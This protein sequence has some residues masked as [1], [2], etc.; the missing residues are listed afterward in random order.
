MHNQRRVQRSG[1]GFMESVTGL[2]TSAGNLATKGLDAVQKGAE[3]AQQGY[4]IYDQYRTV[5]APQQAVPAGTPNLYTGAPYGS[6]PTATTFVPMPS[7]AVP[8]VQSTSPTLDQQG[9]KRLQSALAQ[10]G[11]NPGTVDGI[12]GPNTER[13]L[14]AF[15]SERGLSLDGAPTVY[16]LTLVEAALQDNKDAGGS[17][18][19]P[20][21][22]GGAALLLILGRKK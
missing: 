7:V 6:L 10:L 17:S 22:L 3:V 20:L 4:S 1:L 15:Q 12:F 18:V 14:M 13:A 5:F 9:V 8:S 11:Y 19:L 21:V 2:V 16:N